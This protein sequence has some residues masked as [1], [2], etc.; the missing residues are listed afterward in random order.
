M[1]STQNNNKPSRRLA[2]GIGWPNWT[3]RFGH[4]TNRKP[5]PQQNL[6]FPM[7]LCRNWMCF[8]C[9]RITHAFFFLTLGK[10]D[11]R[12]QPTWRWVQHVWPHHVSSTSVRIFPSKHGGTLRAMQLDILENARLTDI[13]FLETNDG[14]PLRMQLFCARPPATTKPSL[15]VSGLPARLNQKMWVV[16]H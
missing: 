4:K 12:Q 3:C 7:S 11:E 1:R 5:T 10:Y 9:V 15:C 6:I 13:V 8:R 2:P 14:L 16:F